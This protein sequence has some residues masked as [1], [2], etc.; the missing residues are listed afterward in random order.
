MFLN[1]IPIFLTPTDS[2]VLTP[3]YQKSIFAPTF[4][5]NRQYIAPD[6]RPILPIFCP[7]FPLL[8]PVSGKYRGRFLR[9]LLFFTNFVG[10]FE[11]FDL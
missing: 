6:F 11:L 7:D 1:I 2:P 4:I 5:P 8:T 10:I 3:N 9:V